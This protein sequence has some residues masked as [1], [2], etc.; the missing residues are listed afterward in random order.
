M[1]GMIVPTCTFVRV[2]DACLACSMSDSIFDETF[3][4]AMRGRT[5]EG[6]PSTV[7][8]AWQGLGGDGGCG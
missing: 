1:L 3:R 7:I 2:G 4:G 5:P 6:E 8:V